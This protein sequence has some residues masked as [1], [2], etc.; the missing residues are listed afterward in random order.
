MSVTQIAD[1][2]K[3]IQEAEQFFSTE[4]LKTDLKGRSIRGGAVTIAAQGVRF[5]MQMGS[6]VVLARLLTPQDFGLIAMVAALT[7]FALQFKNLGLSTATI[8]KEDINHTQIST[9]FWINVALGLIIAATLV[10]LAPVVAWFYGEPRLMPVTIALAGTFVF[11]GLT[12]QHQALLRRHMRF[13]ALGM[14]TIIAIA[15]GITATIVAAFYGA[16]YWSLVILEVVISVA[17]AVGVWIAF[18]WRP[19]LP[20]R[21]AGVWEMLDFGKNVTAFNLINYFHRNLD[22][23]LLGRFYGSF[24]LGLYN[25]SYRL[26]MLPIQQLRHPINSVALPG[27]SRVQSEPEKF[28][29]YYV[30]LV[31][32]L[33]FIT[34]PLMVF[35]AVFSEDAIELVLGQQWL[36]AVGIFRILAIAAFIQP[37][38]TTRGIVL[39]AMGQSKRYLKSGLILCTA[40]VLALVCG[41]PWGAKGVATCYAVSNYVMLIPMFLYCFRYAPVSLSDFVEGVWRPAL[42]SIGLLIGLVVLREGLGE[43]NI[44]SHLAIGFGMGVALYFCL[45]VVIPGGK[46]LLSMYVSYSKY[47]LNRKA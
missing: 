45:W 7:N 42:A 40:F 15:I 44:V 2:N 29:K 23:I 30:K 34:M 5:I 46:G 13:F 35:L 6:T 22:K 1:Q 21:H 25:K 17:T 36:Q 26:M 31:S 14:V 20:R 9:L 11:S 3:N 12:V 38:F 16:G 19:G 10:V 28:K 47:L 43:G 24:V 32:I 27:L 39:L 18:P 4:H 8:Q 41:L 33:A 37:V